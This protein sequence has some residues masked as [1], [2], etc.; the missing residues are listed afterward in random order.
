MTGGAGLEFLKFK[1]PI[2][3]FTKHY[4]TPK[5]AIRCDFFNSATFESRI[6]GKV[7][8]TAIMYLYL[9]G[10]FLF[11]DLIHCENEDFFKTHLEK[12]SVSKFG[13][14][15]YW[16]HKER[17]TW[18]EAVLQCE[19]SGMEI[20]EVR[21]VEEAKKLAQLMMRNRPGNYQNEFTIFH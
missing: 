21:T 7:T 14:Y 11:L 12:A 9:I 2:L 1:W 3:L 8:Y 19:K 5:Y 16:L 18:P 15:E 10:L 20:A 4:S 13:N 6:R 17:R